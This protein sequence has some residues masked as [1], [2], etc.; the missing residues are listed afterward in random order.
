MTSPCNY[1]ML[2]WF[3]VLNIQDYRNAFICVKDDVFIIAF[4][5]RLKALWILRVEI[6]TFGFALLMFSHTYW[7][8]WTVCVYCYPQIVL[9]FPFLLLLLPF[10]DPLI[11]QSDQH[12]ISPF[13]IILESNIKVMRI[14]EMIINWRI[15][16][17]LDKFSLPAP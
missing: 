15:S 9:F 14:K 3:L 7:S 13:N 17:L 11:P 1:F 12:L 16:W 5:L 10:F 2:I 4:I 8:I 6:T